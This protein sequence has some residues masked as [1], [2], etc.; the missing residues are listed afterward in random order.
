MDE[1]REILNAY[2]S[3]ALNAIAAFHGVLP[4]ESK[5][6]PLVI[7]ILAKTLTDPV[8]VLKIYQGLNRAERSAVD[9]ILRRGGEASVRNVR[10]ELVGSGL[11]DQNVDVKNRRQEY[12]GSRP[13]P[14]AIN[15]RKLEDILVRL[16]LAGLVF[17]AD[18][19]SSESPYP[20]RKRDLD[21]A[22]SSVIIPEAIRL[23][24]PVPPALPKHTE[25]LEVSTI[26]EGS[27]RTFQRDLYLYW[28]YVRDHHPGLTAG[29]E[30]Q[31]KALREVNALLLARSD[32]QTGE[33]EK[34]HPRL[35]FLRE[36]LL[37]LKQIVL[38][39]DRTLESVDSPDFFTLT[40]ARRV[41]Q[42]Y[43]AWSKGKFFN[44]LVLLP[45]EVYFRPS[46]TPLVP[47]PGPITK[48]RNFVLTQMAKTDAEGWTSMRS[49]TEQVRSQNYE[50]LFKRD[51]SLRYYYGARHPY[52][53]S[54]NS[55]GLTFSGIMDEEK[56][57]EMVEANFILGILRWPMFWM[58]LIDLG[59]TGPEK[60][61][62][63]AFRLTPLG[64]WV[65]KLSPEPE[66][67]MEG[68]RVI[69]QPNLHITA[70]DPISDTVL[71]GLDRFAERLT[72]E[73]AIEYR[74]TRA[75]VYVAQQ[76]GWNVEQIKSFLVEHTGS[77]LPGNVERT[78]EE[79]QAQY[80][81]IIF[82][83]QV[84]V[85]H[86][87]PDMLDRLSK[88]PKIAS[89]IA[90]RPLPDIAVLENKQAIPRL[91]KWLYSQ[92]ILPVT[93]QPAIAPGLIR[94][95]GTGE[96]E[97]KVK[98]PNIY[99]HGQLAAFAEEVGPGYRLAPQSI[100]RAVQAGLSA[101]EIVSRLQDMS[102]APL[103][104]EVAIKIRAWAKYY[105]NAELE[106]VVLLQFKDQNTLQELLDDP[107]LGRLLNEYV[108]PA[109]KALARIQPQDLEKLRL[110][111][112]ERGV[113]IIE[114]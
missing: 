14:H 47:A 103:P 39:E 88:E 48:A 90:S 43:E 44:E 36:L 6:K 26:L 65:F 7:E 86:G 31:K 102:G 54:T 107:E 92:E 53:A 80:E 38:R 40:P 34:D 78:L 108:F 89:L 68:G 4:R 35:L 99:L 85:A 75:S 32:I 13:D 94:V 23:Y 2:S 112:A 97:F 71:M 41:L 46:H 105:G 33:S 95:R 114:K 69:L 12:R 58:G 82:H 79:W 98:S 84:A 10:A 17:S 62:P 81:R 3:N 24:L 1:L 56:G 66:I 72:A 37:D 73:R 113:D 111:L 18:E 74:L 83:P 96:I 29:G 45:A 110:L 100:R 49:F 57:W 51:L 61:S 60:G 21:F 104:E 63:G 76:S 15:S 8:K 50:F 91:V 64:R 16:N 42:V 55:M 101:P 20:P 59:W 27:A 25:T 106:K 19:I 87:S 70:L 67:P 11:I 5:S 30:L 93:V 77:S 109:G 22:L 9:A 28:S 52:D